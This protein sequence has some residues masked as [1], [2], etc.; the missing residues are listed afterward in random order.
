[1][2]Y[3]SNGFSPKM[4]N[5][6]MEVNFTIETTTFDEIQENRDELISSIGHDI[7]ADHLNIAKNRINIQLEAGDILYLAYHMENNEFNYKKIT[8]NTI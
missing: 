8:F 7:I 1:M 5:P 6:N 3:V 4:L 2:K